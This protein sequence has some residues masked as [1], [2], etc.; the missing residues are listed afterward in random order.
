[1]WPLFRGSCAQAFR[2]YRSGHLHFRQCPLRL[3]HRS[4]PLRLLRRPLLHLEFWQ[5]MGSAEA[6]SLS[7]APDSPA[8]R[9]L[10]GTL[11]RYQKVEWDGRPW[12]HV[13]RR[14]KELPDK[15]IAVDLPLLHQGSVGGTRLLAPQPAS[16]LNLDG[17]LLAR[18]S[19]P[20]ISTMRAPADAWPVSQRVCPQVSLIHLGWPS[21]QSHLLQMQG[22]E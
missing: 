4:G 16:L 13:W 14:G 9:V 19:T 1:M 17:T 5:V 18:S 2:A 3:R 21:G 15:G 6:P 11:A 7:H 22:V 10:A 20:S 8:C 12:F